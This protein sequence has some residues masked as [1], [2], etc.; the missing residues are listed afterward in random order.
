MEASEMKQGFDWLDEIMKVL[1]EKKKKADDEV[2]KCEELIR[3]NN[4]KRVTAD[5]SHRETLG[6]LN[7]E[8][9]RIALQES[10]DEIIFLSEAKEL[11]LQEYQSVLIA[12]DRLVGLLKNSGGLLKHRKC[13]ECLVGNDS[14]VDSKD[15]DSPSTPPVEKPVEESTA[16]AKKPDA[17]EKPKQSEAPAKL[18]NI[19]EGARPL[20]MLS[21]FGYIDYVICAFVHNGYE[22]GM[23]T[24]DIQNALKKGKD[25]G[26]VLTRSQIS[27]ACGRGIAR[28]SSRRLIK[29][30]GRNFKNQKNLFFELTLAGRKH[31]W[32]KLQDLYTLLFNVEPP[33]L[34][35]TKKTAPV[36][37]K[38]KGK[39]SDKAVAFDLN[40]YQNIDFVLCAAFYANMLEEFT[41]LDVDDT[42]KGKVSFPFTRRHIAGVCYGEIEKNKQDP[43][44]QRNAGYVPKL[45]GTKYH[46][47]EKGREYILSNLVPLIE[48]LFEEVKK[49]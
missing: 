38:K 30:I 25:D 13:V 24:L 7:S 29:R 4:E 6:N 35:K 5:S 17:V 20:A 21:D 49:D 8:T 22:S 48:H 36:Q 14:A 27:G 40:S 44:I 19:D 34:K 9:G 11:L 37:E 46:V 28:K 33:V 12:V 43:R 1:L 18:E 26:V 16:G 10:T 41:T 15:D 39:G 47:T 31:Y 45:K 42:M 3:E 32:E 23:N 2:T